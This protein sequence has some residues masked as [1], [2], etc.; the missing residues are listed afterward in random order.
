MAPGLLML[1]PQHFGWNPETGPSNAF[2]NR[3][4]D[5]L[6][7]QTAQEGQQEF[8][9]MHH[10][11]VEAGLRV[12]VLTDRKEVPCPD[13]VFLN[14]LFCTLPDGG[15]IHF[16]MEAPS[17]RLEKRDDLAHL[18][19]EAGYRVAYES[20][21]SDWAHQGQFL[22]GTG[23]M[24]LDHDHRCAYAAFSTRTSPE[25][26]ERWCHEMGYDGWGFDS[27]DANGR[28]YYHTNV[29]MSLGQNL[30]LLAAE[31]LDPW[32]QKELVKR[33]NSTGRDVLLLSPAQIESF[34]A[35]V[36]QVDH[37]EG[38]RC[39]IASE[40]AVRAWGPEL[41]DRIEADGEIISVSIPTIEKIG[42]GSA[43]CM[44]A[45]NYLPLL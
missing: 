2:Q 10:R 44:L 27:A 8:D 14:N 31:A 21:W 3:E 13:A 33:L 45:E 35:N 23:S 20:D 1:R 39:W 30:A 29:L 15:L 28:P 9:A 17:R 34:G 24:V 7:E 4:P 22:E 32:G 19:I 16:P 25:L 12:T 37:P 18:L 5:G 11:L 36:L 42:G 6:P 43:R 26:L 40:T 41:R 38:H